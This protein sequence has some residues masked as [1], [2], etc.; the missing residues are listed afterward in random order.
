[1]KKIA[2][3]I[4]TIALT[5]G[6]VGCTNN[7]TA[8]NKGNKGSEVAQNQTEN[9]TAN[10]E[11]TTLD[12]NGANDSG[13]LGINDKNSNDNTL[14]GIDLTN[15]NYSNGIYRGSYI[16]EDELTVEFTLANNQ[17]KDIKFIALSNNDD[18]YLED[19]NFKNVKNHYEALINYLKDKDIRQSL[20]D[21]YNPSSIVKDMD[22]KVEVGKVT[23]AIHDALNRGVYSTT[24][25][26][27]K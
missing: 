6:L 7:D 27:N 3:L 11:N 26:T 19:S 24:N 17:I 13:V 25:G 9:G 10:S 5:T 4:A 20:N 21:L 23:S 8:G 14:F 12:G 18:N 22:Q 16:D 1:M 2:L 15:N